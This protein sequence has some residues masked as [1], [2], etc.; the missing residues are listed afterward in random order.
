MKKFY[1]LPS[2]LALSFLLM[3]MSKPIEKETLATPQVQKSVE[4]KT[5]YT[6]PHA[7][8]YLDY[9][10]P[11]NLQIDDRLELQL[12][13][14]VRD[15]AEQLQIEV[16]VSEALLLESG[17]K[18]EFETV[19]NKFNSV[20]VVATG[21]KEGSARINVGATILVAGRYQSRSFSIPVIV[22][23]PTQSKSTVTGVV[24]SKP[25]YRV[26]EAQ[27]VVSMPA[28]ETSE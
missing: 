3:G 9:Q 21:L 19:I 24:I 8:I 11:D 7:G 20:T 13:F 5:H 1:L 16:S 18:F 22:G 26:D 27:G 25:G 17:S 28:V 12:N 2:L 10:R 14:K 15:Q 6:K 4:R 23:E